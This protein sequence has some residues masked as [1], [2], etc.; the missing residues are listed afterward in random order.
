MSALMISAVYQNEGDHC[1]VRLIAL[2]ELSQPNLSG[3][4]TPDFL[5]TAASFSSPGIMSI[6]HK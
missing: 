3:A 2:R 4:W 1:T 5:T 6:N